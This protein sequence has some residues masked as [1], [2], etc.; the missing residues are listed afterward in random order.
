MRKH[1][2]PRRP[3]APMV[4]ALIALF[5][6]FGGV[7]YAAITLPKN[8]VGTRQIRNNAVTWQK[9]AP[10]TV[11]S[12]RINQALVQTRVVGTCMGTNGAIGS[13]AESGQ[14]RCNPS[15]SDEFGS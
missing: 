8:S 7:G 5:F 14:V 6:G 15:A 3:S 4:V 9:I 10:G 2:R 1:F 13:I 12:A 11:G